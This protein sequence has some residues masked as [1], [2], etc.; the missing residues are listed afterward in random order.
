MKKI[1]SRIFCGVIVLMIA[2][3]GC[4]TKSSKGNSGTVAGTQFPLKTKATLTA[5]VMNT[6]AVFDFNN[7]YVTREFEKE[8][9]VNLDFKYSV[10]GDDG[11]TKLNLLMTSGQLPDIF[12]TTGWTKAE[13]LLYGSEGLIIPLNKYLKDAPNWNALNKECPTKQADLTLPNGNIYTYGQVNDCFHCMYQ[14]RMW[15]YKPWV[16]KLLGG[17][18]PTTTDEFYNYL[19]L[20]KTKDPNGDGKADEIPLTGFTASGGWATDPTT[21]LIN[22]FIQSNNFLSNTNPTV[23]AGFVVN[24]GKVQY[25]FMQPGYKEALTYLNKLYKEKLLDNGAFTQDSTQESAIT[26]STTPIAGAVAS[27]YWP[28]DSTALGKGQS[29]VWQN[30]VVL[31]PLKGP[32]GVQLAAYYPSNYFANCVGVVSKSCKD[33]ALAVK[34]FDTLASRKWTLIQGAG[35]ENLGWTNVSSGTS[36][37]GGAATYKENTP[38][39]LTKNNNPDWGLGFADYLWPSDTAIMGNTNALRLAQDAGDAD[40]NSQALLQ[41][42]A[43]TYSPYTPQLDSMMP[44]IAFDE[45]SA[46]KVADYTASIGKY[47]NQATVQ[48]ITGD[49]DINKDWNSYLQKLNDMDVN[50]YVAIEQKGYDAF[51]KS[52]KK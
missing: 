48:F 33:P 10:F 47:S 38:T 19:Q 46:T 44:N 20:V 24:N 43:K 34:V 42:Y 28:G 37:D 17:K 8:N 23:G 32:D 40:L 22:S 5:F 21:F 12:L 35:P 18:M 13:T 49:L 27:G 1:L 11:K 25:Q 7:N 31:P 3:T 9:N 50:G 14:A 51:I 6:Q 16:D 15:I 30:W 29:G 52:T 4:S 45:D 41:K 36:I 39:K 2:L 26:S